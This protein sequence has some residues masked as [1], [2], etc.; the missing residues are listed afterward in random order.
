MPLSN[1]FQS[2]YEETNS[3]SMV[4]HVMLQNY[5][6]TQKFTLWMC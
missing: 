3:L 1:N 4:P 2:Q 6:L 5:S